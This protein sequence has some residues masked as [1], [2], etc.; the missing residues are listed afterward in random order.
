MQPCK[1]CK[2]AGRVFLFT[3][4]SKCKDCGGTGLEQPVMPPA[5]LDFSVATWNGVISAL[6]LNETYIINTD[7]DNNVKEIT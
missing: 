5:N 2:G 3:S 6:N 1:C 4:A 7:G